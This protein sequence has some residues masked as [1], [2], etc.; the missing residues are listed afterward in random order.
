MNTLV[1]SNQHDVINEINKVTPEAMAVSIKEFYSGKS[2][3][4]TRG[5]WLRGSENKDKDGKRIFNYYA[6]DGKELHPKI[7]K[8]I[9]KADWYLEP[10]DCGTCMLFA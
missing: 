2:E 8:I 5:I 6:K 3:C 1:I 9:K 10:Y 4:N 7:A